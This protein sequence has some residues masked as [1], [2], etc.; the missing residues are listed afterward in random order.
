M[1]I[2]VIVFTPSAPV[3]HIQGHVLYLY[4][5]GDCALVWSNSSDWP[6]RNTK[7]ATEMI[8]MMTTWALR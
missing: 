8:W 6:P 4:I 3:W 7:A 2:D 5:M 1:D